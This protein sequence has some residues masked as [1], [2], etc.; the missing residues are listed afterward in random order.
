MSQKTTPDKNEKKRFGPRRLYLDEESCSSNS[1]ENTKVKTWKR[2]IYKPNNV[3]TTVAI[4]N[5]PMGRPIPSIHPTYRPVFTQVYP[6]PH[7]PYRPAIP[8][9]NAMPPYTPPIVARYPYNDARWN[10]AVTPVRSPMYPIPVPQM[11]MNPWPVP[12]YNSQV[13]PYS[14]LI[15]SPIIAPDPT[16]HMLSPMAGSV[17]PADYSYSQG[18]ESAYYQAGAS[19]ASVVNAPYTNVVGNE[20]VQ[21][22]K[23]SP[24]RSRAEFKPLDYDKYFLLSKDLFQPARM[25]KFNPNDLIDQFCRISDCSK[26]LPWL[27]DLEYGVPRQPVTRPIAIYD[28]KTN[29]ICCKNAPEA[30]HPGFEDCNNDFKGPFMLYYDAIVSSWYGGYMLLNDDSSVENF[31]RWLQVPM[32][33]VGMCW[34]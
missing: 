15:G 10:T 30:I 21:K 25:I 7:S 24:V 32:Q 14:S 5:P 9:Y 12:I 19:P 31:Q 17:A 1:Q 16:M 26:I 2:R 33:K 4:V 20:L 28:S 11:P 27:L 6:P 13:Y 29:T 34:A 3:A 8:I 22:L 23:I 18:F